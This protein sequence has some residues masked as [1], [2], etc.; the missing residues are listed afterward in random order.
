MDKKSYEEELE[1]TIIDIAYKG[2][3][4]ARHD[5][6]VIFVPGVIAGEVV[7]V[8][9]VKR[10]KKYAEAEL[11]EVIKPSESRC[12]SACPLVDVCPGCQYQ[13]MSYEEEVRVKQAQLVSFLQRQ[14]G[15]E[16]S[17]CGAPIESPVA[18]GYRNKIVLHAGKKPTGFCLGFVG[19]DNRKVFDVPACP[20]AVSQIN[21]ELADVRSKEGFLNSLKHGVSIE[22]RWTPVNGVLFRKMRNPRP[23]RDAKREAMW[24]GK[25]GRKF[26]PKPP[27]VTSEKKVFI[28]EPTVLGELEVPQGSFFQVNPAVADKLV[29]TVMQ[30]IKEIQPETVIDLFC[31]AGVLAL[32]A[33]KAGVQHVLG[34][35]MDRRAIRSA[36]RNAREMGLSGVEFKGMSVEDGLESALPLVDAE[37]NTLILD[38][39]RRGLEKNVAEMICRLKPRNIIMVS[40][41]ADTMARDVA[42]LASAGYRVKSSQLFDMFPRTAYFESVTWLTMGEGEASMTADG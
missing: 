3:G 41:A 30:L 4:V 5:G 38:P 9:I 8:G 27:P 7:R 1:L 18:L 35:D 6:C 33:G 28:R 40:C 14:V 39:P 13:H 21:E 24:L 15:I 23:S 31:G 37:K 22:F 42:L 11:I 32:A 17:V 34:I 10:R 20:L 25:A 19:A 12:D 29:E 26:A 2:K 36:G 16:P